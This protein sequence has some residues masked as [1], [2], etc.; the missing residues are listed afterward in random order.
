MMI[1]G[2]HTEHNDRKRTPGTDSKTGQ[3]TLT[4]E[5][6]NDIVPTGSVPM[7]L[8]GNVFP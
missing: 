8:T 6:A 4:I 7:M 3:S 2:T 5:G 1:R